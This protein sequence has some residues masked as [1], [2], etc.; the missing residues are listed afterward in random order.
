MLR[1]TAPLIRTLDGG[2]ATPI[3]AAPRPECCEDCRWNRIN[4]PDAEIE[5]D[6]DGA[7]DAYCEH[8]RIECRRIEMPNEH[9]FP[10]WCPMGYGREERR[11]GRT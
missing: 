3:S 9:M 4:C 8:P 2:L 1:V 7:I 6:T 10:A 5:D 11:G